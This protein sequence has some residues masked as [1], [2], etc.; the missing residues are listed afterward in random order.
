MRP[1]PYPWTSGRQAAAVVGRDLAV[2]RPLTNQGRSPSAMGVSEHGRCL[3]T[4]SPPTKSNSPPR[5]ALVRAFL[6]VLLVPW[7]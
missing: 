6:R 2:P 3:R 7:T 1:T 4:V 5:F